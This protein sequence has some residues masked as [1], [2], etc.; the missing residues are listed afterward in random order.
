MRNIII[1]FAITASATA[2]K[3]EDFST[4]S[5]DTSTPV[6]VRSVCGSGAESVTQAAACWPGNG[7][8]SAQLGASK[9]VAMAAIVVATEAV[10]EGRLNKPPLLT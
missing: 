3:A 4:A 7:S 10:P 1:A 9:A 5:T 8:A 2:T 6:A